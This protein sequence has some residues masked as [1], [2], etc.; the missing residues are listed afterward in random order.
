MNLNLPFF[1]LTFLKLVAVFFLPSAFFSLTSEIDS[2]N[3]SEIFFRSSAK[4][5][6]LCFACILYCL[7][8]SDALVAMVIC[9]STYHQVIANI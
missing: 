3:D 8:G 6:S 4:L 9:I 2:E 7:I 5:S 1:V